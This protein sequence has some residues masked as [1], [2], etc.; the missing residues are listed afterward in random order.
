M[1][2]LEHQSIEKQGS[3]LLN[4]LISE[5]PIFCS[6]GVQKEIEIKFSNFIII[7]VYLKFRIAETSLQQ[8]PE[9]LNILG[10]IFDIFACI[11]YI[12]DGAGHYVSHSNR[13][14]NRWQRYDDLKTNISNSNKTKKMKKQIVFVLLKKLNV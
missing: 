4:K 5:K 14:N 6:C 9:E 1:D 2:M 12:D 13:R 10:I 7:D 8:I 3:C 11:E